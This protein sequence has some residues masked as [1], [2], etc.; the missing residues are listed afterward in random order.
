MPLAFADGLYGLRSHVN[1]VRQRILSLTGEDAPAEAVP[2]Q[3]LPA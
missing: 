2:A 1:F 3:P